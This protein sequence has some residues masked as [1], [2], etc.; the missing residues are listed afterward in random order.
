MEGE[1]E[2]GDVEGETRA[3]EDA[4]SVLTESTREVLWLPGEI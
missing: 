1:Q 2:E 3:R 4:L